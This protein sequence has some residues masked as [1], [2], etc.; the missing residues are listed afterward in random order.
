MAGVAVHDKYSDKIGD[1]FQPNTFEGNGISSAIVSANLELLSDENMD[2][3]G[4]A[5]QFGAEIKNRLIEE[6]KDIGIVGEV[7]GKGLMIG[8]ELVKDRESREPFT[9]IRGG[10]SPKAMNRGVKVMSC[11]RNNNIIRLMPPLV[12]TRDYFNKGIDVLLEVLQEEA[13]SV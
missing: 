9:N 1:I 8:I 6:T 12:I 3:I 2:L 13:K 4:R 11:G 10:I 7:R 5:A